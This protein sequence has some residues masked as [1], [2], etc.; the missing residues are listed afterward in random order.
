MVTL[1]IEVIGGREIQYDQHEKE[2]SIFFVGPLSPSPHPH[3]PALNVE[4]KERKKE[5]PEKRPNHEF[6][7]IRVNRDV[8]PIGSDDGAEYSQ[9]H[10][11]GNGG[12][13]RPKRDPKIHV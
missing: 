12:N 10:Q 4:P 2:V 11:E 6:K 5:R 9:N 1:P 7:W 8:R 3:N 13:I